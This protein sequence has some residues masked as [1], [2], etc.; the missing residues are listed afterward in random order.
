[1]LPINLR[2]ACGAAFQVRSV[3]LLDLVGG[4]FEID[5]L[6]VSREHAVDFDAIVAAP[7][8]LEINLA[9]D[10]GDR[11]RHLR[12]VCS[13]IEHVGAEETGLSTYRLQLVPALWM[14]TRNRDYCIFRRMSVPEIVADVLGEWG[15]VAKQALA[16][17]PYPADD[18]R[19]QYDESDFAFIC[20]LLEESGITLVI[21]DGE[22][23]TEIVL[24]DHLE[25]ETARPTALHWADQ[26]L[27]PTDTP[28]ATHVVIRR[29]VRPTQVSV[30]DFDFR[31]KPGFALTGKA[32]SPGD[33]RLVH[34][35]YER[36]SL[37]DD[38]PSARGRAGVA[39]A[40]ARTRL[41][42]MRDGECVIRFA[43]N[44]LDLSP[45]DVFTIE[46]HPRPELAKNARLLVTDVELNLRIGEEWHLEV[47]AVL[48]DKPY[49]PVRRNPRPR[50]HSVQSAIVVG[51]AGQEIHTDAFGRVRIQL[52]WDHRGVDD[53]QSSCWMRVS[54]GWA[55]VG[56]GMVT[57]PRIGH[58][59]LVGFIDGDPDQPI[60]VGSVYNNLAM[61]PYTLPKHAT[62]STLRSQSTPHAAGY[63]ELSFED[64]AGQEL[65]YIRA[66]RDLEQRI[67][68]N[69]KF[70]V[71]GSESRLVKGSFT[72]RV[73]GNEQVTIAGSL[74][75]VVKG[76]V[77]ESAAS[78]DRH[79]TGALSEE[80]EGAL[81]L[82]VGGNHEEKVG[83]SFAIEAGDEIHIKAGGKLIL[84]AGAQLSLKGPGGFIDIGPSGVAIQGSMILINS[85]GSAGSGSGAS[86]VTPA[87]ATEVPDKDPVT[88]VG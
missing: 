29:E 17:G 86:P 34:Y 39:N 33:S 43:T 27:N 6:A 62:I 38:K 11:I 45:G 16:G 54:H 68:A 8:E 56:F 10:T 65:V 69:A 73:D 20:R 78:V 5:I 46:G 26:R 88:F 80:V 53:E 61:P 32:T 3:N 75:H 25:Q 31:N 60:V 84:E 30:R 4:L 67:R 15:L 70:S 18:Y 12:G 40:I 64:A 42:S 72:E 55:G 71:G 1:M 50:I 52:P 7:A 44:A 51:P 82:Q 83:A 57:I 24:H 2:L 37:I 79:I 87:A 77:R 21:R 22:D 13:F 76:K 81:S 48:A 58:E 36:G 66:Q 35:Q 74:D 19:V 49:R 63:N 85:G 59:V 9:T 47:R 14:A 23:A 41:L 28:F